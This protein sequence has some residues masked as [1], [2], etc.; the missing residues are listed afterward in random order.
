MDGGLL[1]QR[2]NNT[3]GNNNYFD[4][5]SLSGLHAM[6]HSDDP[7]AKREALHEIGGQF[8]AMLIKQMLD[9]MRE[10]TNTMFEDSLFNPER[11]RFY[12][13]MLDDQMSVELA[14]ER[15]LGL[16]EQFVANLSERYGLESGKSSG[17]STIAD[18][19]YALNTTSFIAQLQRTRL[20][21][22]A[23]QDNAD[24]LA[25]FPFTT[26]DALAGSDNRE[27]DEVAVLER[28]STSLLQQESNQF[29]GFLSG[30]AP[31]S[32][33]EFI[34]ALLPYAERVGQELGVDPENVLAQAALETG[35]GEKIIRGSDG[36]NSFNLFGIKAD[37]RWSGDSLAVRTTEFFGGKPLSV[38]A[39][40]RQYGSYQDSFNDFVSFLK[41]N[42]RYEQALAADG[43]DF[44]GDLQ[45]AGYATDPH[46]AKKITGLA[47]RIKQ[48]FF[49]VGSAFS[50]KLSQNGNLIVGVMGVANGELQASISAQAVG[51]LAVNPEAL[52][53]E[54]F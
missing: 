40:F 28:L 17:S 16:S 41:T 42:S 21:R 24:V 6:A 14:G 7:A 45:K 20:D 52:I 37:S 27:G 19:G 3:S 8:E 32:R 46:Y 43:G 30:E 31:Q 4:A 12:Q 9:S 47:E 13:S 1:P 44:Y 33:R 5:R 23:T 38:E 25:V 53:P 51:G 36:Q 35:W 49:D 2:P 10:T 29:R 22:T 34:F 48:E 54:I 18:Q 15:G 50:Q 39:S 11:V 26:T